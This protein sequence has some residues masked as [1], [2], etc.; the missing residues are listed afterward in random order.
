MTATSSG[1]AIA[2]QVSIE[3]FKTA[4]KESLV[5]RREGPD[6]IVVVV[7]NAQIPVRVPIVKKGDV[8]IFD[9]EAMK[10]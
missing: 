7:G 9:V 4:A 3:G 10:K 2:D 6:R 5:L 1:N 8:W